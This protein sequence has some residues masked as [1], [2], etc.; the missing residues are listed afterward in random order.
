MQGVAVR[1]DITMM[2]LSK[3]TVG[4]MFVLLGGLGA[5]HGGS[6]GQSWEILVGVL[7]VISGV[8]LLV[9]KILRR[10]LSRDANRISRYVRRM[11]GYRSQG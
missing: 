4:L 10:D 3:E 2:L 6:A 5:A 8:A 9:A 7:L 11:I 1:T